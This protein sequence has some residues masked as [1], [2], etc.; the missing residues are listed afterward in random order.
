MK[1]S[2]LIVLCSL[3]LSIPGPGYVYVTNGE[4]LCAYALPDGSGVSV[5]YRDTRIVFNLITPEYENIEQA[6]SISGKPDKT[7][8]DCS[9]NRI[10]VW[11]NWITGE[12]WRYD[13]VLPGP[14][15][16]VSR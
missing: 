3:M 7:I 15:D 1:L 8:C 10:Q 14:D 12:I 11:A 9:S 5:A 16:V 6:V 2:A 4:L 13:W